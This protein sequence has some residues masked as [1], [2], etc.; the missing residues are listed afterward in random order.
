M[1][2]L[3]VCLNGGAIYDLEAGVT[4]SMTPIAGT[5][6]AA[7]VRRLRRSFPQ[8][9]FASDALA[10]FEYEQGFLTEEQE[11]WIEDK[12]A[13]EDVVP[14]LSAGVCKLVGRVDGVPSAALATQAADVVGTDALLTTSGD[15]WIDLSAPGVTKASGLAEVCRML[16]VAPAEVV[17][18]GDNRND[19]E[20]LRFAGVAAVVANAHGEAKALADLMLPANV[21]DGVAQLI[22]ALVAA[23]RSGLLPLTP[24]SAGC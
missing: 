14:G 15:S 21:D 22:E 9:L 2:G 4:V 3:A 8:M 10:R 17:A 18:C 20:M 16:G 6:A 19:L 24:S 7:L 13:V 5:V 23:D 11:R 1:R 12:I